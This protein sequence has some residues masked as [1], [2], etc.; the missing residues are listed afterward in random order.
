MQQSS[1]CLP[2]PVYSLQYPVLEVRKEASSQTATHVW[3]VAVVA[4]V[5]QLLEC[6]AQ[7]ETDLQVQV[8]AVAGR[9]ATSG[10]GKSACTKQL[11]TEAPQ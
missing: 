9:V 4:G 10:L 5:A 11:S 8:A 1:V 2:L 3:L 7:M 6:N